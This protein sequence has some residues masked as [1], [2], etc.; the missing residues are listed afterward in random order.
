MPGLPV[1]TYV[2]PLISSII[3]L[4]TC[5]TFNNNFGRNGLSQSLNFYGEYEL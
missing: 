3:N 5:Q 4:M 2:A 1:G